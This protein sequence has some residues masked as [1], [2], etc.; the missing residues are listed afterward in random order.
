[1]RP[2]LTLH[3][4]TRAKSYYDQ[5]LWN[6]DTFYGLMAKHTAARPAAAA[7]RDGR[8]RLTWEEAIKQVDAIAADFRERGLISGDRVSVW[9]SNRLMVVLVFIACSREGIAC[10]PSL[11]RTQT[12]SEV[13]E[14]L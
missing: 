6:H 14:L 12:C 3:D 13:V 8:G 1:M 10:N 9:A 5:G 2:F 4:P 7:I 11:H